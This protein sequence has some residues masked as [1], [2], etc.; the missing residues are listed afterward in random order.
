LSTTQWRSAPKG[1]DA[2]KEVGDEMEEVFKNPGEFLQAFIRDEKVSDQERRLAQ[3]MLEDWDKV[4]LPEKQNIEKLAGD[5]TEESAQLRRPII[6]KR[7]SFWHA[8]EPD[9]DL[10][11]DEV[12]EDDFE[13]DDIMAMAHAKLE[14]HRE[15]R[16]YARIAVWEMPL[17]SSKLS[18]AAPLVPLFVPAN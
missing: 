7:D 9:Q 5:I 2:E 4:P 10:I 13:E 18:G 15:F 12:G 16:E 17:L 8:D 1:D 14:E 11:T 6:P 3:R